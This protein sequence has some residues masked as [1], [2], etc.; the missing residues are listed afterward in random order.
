M[1]NGI[2]FW[3]DDKIWRGILT[4]LGAELAQRDIADVIFKSNKKFSP[5]ELNTELLRLADLHESE[6]IKKICGNVPLS[7][8]QKKIIMTLHRFGKNGID[9]SALQQQLGYA[10]GAATNAVGTA[11]YQL[12]KILGKDFIKNEGGKYK[13]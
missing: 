12:R 9:V 5:A 3:T 10:P 4:D 11:I 1:F 8:A 6:I 7:G 13:L 2:T